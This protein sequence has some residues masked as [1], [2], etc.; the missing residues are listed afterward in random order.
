MIFFDVGSIS[1][2]S[3]KDGVNVR[4]IAE[5]FGVGGHDAA[6][7]SPIPEELRTVFVDKFILKQD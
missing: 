4:V 2:W 3:I 6:S 7:S 1:Y 5:S